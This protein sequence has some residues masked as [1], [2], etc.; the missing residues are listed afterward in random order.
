MRIKNAESDENR[1]MILEALSKY[2]HKLK[3]ES[4]ERM[5]D[6]GFSWQN[7][8]YEICIDEDGR[9]IELHAL[10]IMENETTPRALIVPKSIEERS[11][12]KIK[13]H[14]LWDNT[15]YVLGA[16]NKEKPERAKAA[17]NAFKSYHS[18]VADVITDEGIIA[19]LKFL[20]NWNPKKACLLPGWDDMAG[21]NIVFRLKSEKNFVHERPVVT[22]YWKKKIN[23][24]KGG[25]CSECLVTGQRSEIARIHPTIKG[26]M[27]AQKKG[28]SII[29]FNKDAFKSYGKDQSF[30]SPV[31]VRSA[32][33]YTT[34]LNHLLRYESENKIQIG[35]AA[36]VFWSDERSS[37]ENIVK[38][39]ISPGYGNEESM[40][41]KKAIEEPDVLMKEINP[42]AYFNFLT[43]SPNGSRLSV[44]LWSRLRAYE[45]LENLRQHFMDLKIV[46]TYET[47]PDY[48][49][50][51]KLLK[52]TALQRKTENISPG[53]AGAVTWSVICR[54]KYP[55]TLLIA[56]INRIRS[57]RIVNYV[58]ASMIK[59]YL[60]RSSRM[61]GEETEVS[62]SLNMTTKNKSYRLGRL[63][64][65]LEKI[66]RKT[67]TKIRSSLK[68]RYY[69]Y[70]SATPATVFPLLLR[71]NN[72]YIKKLKK[73][74]NAVAGEL[75]KM[76]EEIVM[77]I[78][79]FPENLDLTSQGMFALGYYHQKNAISELSDT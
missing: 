13:P 5:P 3:I 22:S 32:F 30:N 54:E 77:E 66:Q 60:V 72:E 71:Q 55:K 48:P 57:D 78:D 36:A 47:E 4:P 67:L 59:A 42:D 29:S 12:A 20:N 40:A 37:V 26:I 33:Y 70:A 64:A 31:G 69:T 62:V 9:L 24:K 7:I 68:D 17:F 21:K 18:H 58:R 34:A 51:W 15:M 43:L 19:V 25:F 8:H 65:V 76:L 41:V 11:G 49:G 1:I 38:I 2:Y 6:F 73:D 35:D 50:L 63:L 52:E 10:T 16:D 61:N 28:A 45:I 75:E 44:R 14:F 39:L 53:L 46:K 56:L 74:K 23:S 79:V 27:G